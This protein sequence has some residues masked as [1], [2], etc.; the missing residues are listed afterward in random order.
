MT[1]LSTFKNYYF[2][3]RNYLRREFESDAR[4]HRLCS[5]LSGCRGARTRCRPAAKGLMPRANT[6]PCRF[7]LLRVL[8]MQVTAPQQGVLLGGMCRGCDHRAAPSCAVPSQTRRRNKLSSQDEQEQQ[9][10]PRPGCRVAP[11]P[12]CKAKQLTC[13]CP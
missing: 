2:L 9:S 4:R 5:G 1:S 3:N 8:P 12:G 11:K 10:R 13:C 6:E 7:Q